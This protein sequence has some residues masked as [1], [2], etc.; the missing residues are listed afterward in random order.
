MRSKIGVVS[1]GK[2]CSELKREVHEL[3]L[4]ENFIFAE[5]LMYDG[6]VLPNKLKEADILISSG[7]NTSILKKITNQPI[8]NIEPSLFDIL[9]SYSEAIVIDPRP[10]IIFPMFEY[11]ELIEQIK[12]ILSVEI[13]TDVYKDITQLN[14]I[15][16]S[17][18]ANGSKCIIG[19]GLV[20]T[21]AEK[22]GLRSVFVYPRESLRSYIT[23]AY[24]SA[25]AIHEKARENKFLSLALDNVKDGLMFTDDK[26]TILV[27]NP[28][29]RSLFSD[30]SFSDIIG[31]N[32]LDLTDNNDMHK[33]YLDFMSVK[34]VV[35]EFN[36][37]KFIFAAHPIYFH[38]IPTNV[39]LSFYSIST[40]RSQESHIRNAMTN[41]KYLAKY[42]FDDIITQNRNYAQIIAKAKNYA[43]HDKNILISGPHG[44]SKAVLAQAIH[45][46]SNRAKYPFVSVN[47]T[48]E[49]DTML[50]SEL[51]GYEE[52]VYPSTRRT[53]HTG[54]IE[55]AQDGTIYFDEISDLSLPLQAKLL[56]MIKEG[57]IAHVGSNKSIPCNVRVIAATN[58]DLWQLVCEH[59]FNESLYYSL[60]ILYLNM[61]RLSDRPEDILPLFISFVKVLDPVLATRFFEI[62]FC[63]DTVL[64][65]YSWPGNVR[66]LEN[67]A[68]LIYATTDPY[69]H[70][71]KVLKRVEEEITLLRQ[72][73][74]VQNSE[75]IN[76]EVTPHDN[77]LSTNYLE[78]DRIR[79]AITDT[80]GN[81]SRAA[82]T[83][84]ISRTTLWRKMKALGINWNE[85][86]GSFNEH[87]Q[88][89]SLL[90]N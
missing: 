1:M 38:N 8:V 2:L 65:S 57:R 62:D 50:E 21:E 58:R 76:K 49:T 15:I 5:L 60:S 20:C 52:I 39:V 82:T 4:E 72:R 3:G 17:H 54:L 12:N 26:G 42:H 79:N 18:K 19:S 33:L 80:N 22:A 47:C 70:E 88:Y 68:Y 37:E 67:F 14:N 64:R 16:F 74:P 10:V 51:L 41:H 84:G 81:Y 63:L 31:E 7:Y 69:E 73:N 27:C 56:R 23:L 61:P 9:H 25:T 75:S 30:S 55:T 89:N 87:E 48:A 44:S 29:A 34:N 24:D 66:E 86:T 11:S 78:A 35:T 53:T 77:L 36:G 85:E 46:S 28:V 40:I 83:L 59:K 43:Q 6:M 45:N 32:I 90:V 71:E 13:I